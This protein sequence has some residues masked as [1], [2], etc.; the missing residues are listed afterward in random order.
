MREQV[1]CVASLPRTPAG[2]SDLPG[3]AG[4]RCCRELCDAMQCAVGTQD[5]RMI[6]AI[7]AAMLLR[8]RGLEWVER[9][10]ISISMGA[11]WEPGHCAY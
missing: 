10:A 3:A 7:S 2:H 9:S 8:V 11:R 5:A 1:A 4:R 6:V